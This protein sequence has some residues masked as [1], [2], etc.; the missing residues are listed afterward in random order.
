MVMRLEIEEMVT[1]EELVA[2]T[3]GKGWR[4]DLSSD[5]K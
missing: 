1:V 5:T 3:A 2:M 4:W